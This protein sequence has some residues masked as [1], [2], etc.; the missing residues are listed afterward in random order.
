MLV[1]SADK[2]GFIEILNITFW[3]YILYYILIENKQWRNAG[4]I[5]NIWQ[6]MCSIC[7][8]CN[9]PVVDVEDDEEGGEGCDGEDVKDARVVD[10][11]ADSVLV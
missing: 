3:K 9:E 7:V 8:V 10:N 4:W 1:T 2:R 6:K 11:K 5:T